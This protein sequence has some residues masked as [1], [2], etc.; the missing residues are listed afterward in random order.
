[1]LYYYSILASDEFTEQSC[2][3]F[4]KQTFFKKWIFSTTVRFSLPTRILFIL[5]SGLEMLDNLIK[6]GYTISL[7]WTV[8]L[9]SLHLNV[10]SHT[11]EMPLCVDNKRRIRVLTIKLNNKRRIWEL[12]IREE[13]WNWVV[14]VIML[15]ITISDCV[16]SQIYLYTLWY[17][18]VMERYVRSLNFF[19]N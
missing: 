17:S 15:T 12:K 3:L 19:Y 4:H 1:M 5:L 9:R 6:T 18:Y 2:F 7:P 11:E 16:Y 8:V 13:Y 10:I 14:L